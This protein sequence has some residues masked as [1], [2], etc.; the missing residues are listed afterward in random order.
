MAYVPTEL[1]KAGSKVDVELLGKLYTG[2]VLKGAP[3]KIESMRNK[4]E[5]EGGKTER[6][7]AKK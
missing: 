7:S 3:F 1:S 5:K 4:S 2:T 6:A